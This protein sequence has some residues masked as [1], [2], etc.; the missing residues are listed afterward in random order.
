[1]ELER[2]EPRWLTDRIGRAP[3]ASR[4]S[5]SQSEARR[6]WRRAALALDNYRTAIGARR[7]G[8]AAEVPADPEL[9]PHH[10]TARRAVADLADARGRSIGR[11]LGD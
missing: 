1:V 2:D 6:A 4:R 5:I 7:F 3:R 8:D 11:G 10:E 9:R